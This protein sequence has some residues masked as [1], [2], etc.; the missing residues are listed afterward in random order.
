MDQTWVNGRV[1]RNTFGWG[2][3]RT[4]RLPAGTLHAGEN[5]I[6]LNVLSTW[7]AGGLIGPADAM[8]LTFDDGTKVPLG[9]R[10]ALPRRAARRWAVRRAPR[11]RRLRA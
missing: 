8:A 3:P 1:I 7:D 2:T 9:E 4:Y 10:V 5:V 6:V 11:G